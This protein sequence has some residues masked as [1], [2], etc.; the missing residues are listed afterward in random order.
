MSLLLAAGLASLLR[1]GSARD[2]SFWGP[3]AD[4]LRPL[5][6]LGLLAIPYLP[7]LA[8]WVPALRLLAGPG[9]FVIW[10][11]VIGQV[12]MVAVP[13]FSAS[14]SAWTFGIASV[15]F[16]VPFVFNLAQLPTALVDVFR[17]VQHLPS[18]HW[19]LVPAGSLGVLFDQEYG[20]FPFAPVLILAFAGI[21]AMLGEPSRARLAMALGGGALSLI[22]LAGTL[23]PWWSKSAMPGEQLV[24]LLPFLAPPI[25]WW[26]GRRQ[27][28][29]LSRAAA[30]VLLFFSVA[31]TLAIAMGLAPAR[32]EADG[33]S[34]LLQWMSPTW[35]LWSEVPTYV[36][37]DARS[38]TVRVA[39]WLT[40]FALALWL[41]SRRRSP[42]PGRAAL[43][44]TTTLALLAIALVSAT[45][46]TIT[47]AA[48]RFDIERR[49]VFQ[50]LE[51]FD[52]I[53]RPTAIRYDAFS[54]VS[55]DEL[56]PLFV[57]SAVPGERTDPQPVRVILNARFRLPAG[58]YVVDLLGS[59]TAGAAPNAALALQVGRE[60][61]P[62]ESWPLALGRGERVRR[63]FEVP[64]DAEFIGFR[65]ARSV[66]QSIAELRL[67]PVHVVETRKRFRTGTVLSAAVFAVAK[68]FFHDSSA[69][70]EAGGFWVRGRTTARMTLLKTRESDA[71][72]VLAI[73][74]G[75]RPNVVTLA[76][77][78][79]SQKLELVPGVTE[80]VTVPSRE[81]ERFVPLTI[82]SA[83]GFVPAE[84]EQ[85]GDRRLLGAWI[86]FIPDD[87]ARTSATP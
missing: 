69:Y 42:S 60:G 32:Q 22:I 13:R 55:P 54:L 86:A 41:F 16:S 18:T 78:G 8:D 15:A 63:E 47:D 11:V 36:V 68:M 12:L 5:F 25:A 77:P 6:A 21:G 26:Y 87:T 4:A 29:S 24:L 74:S 83:D 20:I 49:A 2:T 44:A 51:T 84:V 71:G 37:G 67:S 79:W 27:P 3:A 80:R 9:R 72:V 70:P 43:T 17:T 73:H 81:G 52:P 82:S 39:A 65:A 46:A 33:A 61:R 57:A 38:A 75:A 28:E 76:A 10:V 58:R 31:V 14:T 48:S 56:P 7:W 59:D 53:A 35:Q 30:Q 1:I 62:I 19:S 34:G 66:E 40:T 85:S 23:D 64:L 45:S 50:L